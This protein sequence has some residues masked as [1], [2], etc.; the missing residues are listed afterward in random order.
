MERWWKDQ[1]KASTM[2]TEN[3]IL[4]L[5]VMDIGVSH[6]QGRQRRRTLSDTRFSTREIY[7]SI[8][9]SVPPSLPSSLHPSLHSS[10]IY[11]STHPSIYLSTHPSIYSSTRP[12][13]STSLCLA[14]HSSI[15][16]F[17]IN[18]SIHPPADLSISRPAVIK[19]Q[20]LTH[21]A[22]R[23]AGTHTVMMA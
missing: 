18:P 8:H 1:A 7:P 11:L 5:K 19:T 21:S 20:L 9:P 2:Q 16:P 3:R 17:V 4:G 6:S 23:K 13:I 14:L 12:S 22:E 10:P 15:H